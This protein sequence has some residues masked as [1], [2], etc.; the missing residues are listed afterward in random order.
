MT[1]LAQLQTQIRYLTNTETSNFVT[2]DEL[3]YYINA[4][5]AEL[6]DILVSKQ[7]DYRLSNL[8]ATISTGN[9]IPLPSDFYQLRLVQFYTYTSQSQPWVNVDLFMLKEQSKYSNTFVANN[10]CIPFL[11]YMLQDG[12]IAIVP[13]TSAL[14][15]YKVWYTPVYQQLV[16]QT[17][18]IPSYF[19]NQAWR[20]YIVVD[21]AI[22]VYNKQT[23]DP[24]IFMAQKAALKIRIDAMAGHR[25]AGSPKHVVNNRGRNGGGFD[26]GGGFG[27]GGGMSGF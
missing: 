20:E 15:K 7:E 25:D 13:E 18:T 16:N 5:A 26:G 12:Y 2:Q 21:C 17:D 27:F 23:L 9:L 1:T 11:H 4:S 22:K 8:T 14:G 24:S 3:T 6:D 19:E 10:Y